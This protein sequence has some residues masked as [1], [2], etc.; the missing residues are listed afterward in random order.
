MFEH[1]D[2][3]EVPD[4]IMVALEDDVFGIEIG[5]EPSAESV[6][7]PLRDAVMAPSPTD[8]VLVNGVELT[9]QSAFRKFQRSPAW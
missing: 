4:N 1:V 2:G 6:P 9:V 3:Q 7:V 5:G 8:M